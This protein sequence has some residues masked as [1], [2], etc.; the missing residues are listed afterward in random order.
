MP[1]VTDTTSSTAVDPKK[2]AAFAL[3]EEGR[4]LFLA[5][6]Y[7]GALAKYDAA[8]P[9]LKDDP[10]VHELRALALFALGDYHE[11]AATLNALLAVAPG[12]DWQSM[13]NQY[14][15][16]ATYTKQ[17]R[18]LEQF[19]RDHPDDAAARFVL[20]YHYLVTNF[21][22][23][24]AKQFEKVVELEPRDAVAKKLLDSLTKDKKPASPD[25]TP[26]AAADGTSPETDLVGNW[27]AKGDDGSEFD[28]TLMQ[29]GNFTWVV[30]P[31]KG[32]VVKQTGTFTATADRLILDADGQE[33]TLMARVESRGPDHFRFW[34]T[35]DANLKFHREGVNSPEPAPTVKAED[36][37]TLPEA[38]IPQKSA[39]PA[40]PEAEE[41][42]PPALELPSPSEDPADA[43]PMT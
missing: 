8:I 2:E 9:D 37:G 14:P 17:L 27:I 34:I 39:P 19:L 20:G 5:G 32:N 13:R 41:K 11:A 24:A 28:L 3:V 36:S 43:V 15:D 18:A 21:A 6:D 35:D 30:T 10:I 7:Q 22:D 38:P 16:V 29:D 4:K 40:T 33:T 12:M 26:P 1:L 31:P 42:A 23:A 25:T